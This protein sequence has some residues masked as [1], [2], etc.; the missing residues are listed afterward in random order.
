MIHN[1]LH[2]TAFTVKK[3]FSAFASFDIIIIMLL[4]LLFISSSPFHNTFAASPA[5]DLQ[6]LT[7]QRSDWV[8]TYGNDS[9]HLKSDYANLL[10]TDYLSDGKTLNATFWL[11]SNL[12][13]ASAYNQTFKK[14]SYGMLI[15][16]ASTTINA[17]YNGADYDFYIKQLMEN[18]VN[19]FT[20]YHQQVPMCS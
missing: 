1:G 11:A 20:N 4:L 6:A 10:E 15:D 12:E 19:I 14:I 13:N 2:N 3:Y 5:F 18:G 16:I 8:Q 17:G 9:T 7:D